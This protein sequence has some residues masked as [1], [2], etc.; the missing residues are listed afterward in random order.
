MRISDWS[1]DVCSSDLVRM[2]E[3]AQRLAA[4]TGLDAWRDRLARAMGPQARFVRALALGDTRELSD[5]DW[6]VL[7][8]T[9]LTHLIAIS[10][11][12][13]GQ[14]GRAPRRARVWQYV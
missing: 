11:F 5:R 4:A 9:G 1:S 2:P 13:V 12:H 7:R 3:A 8:A 6:E 14:I 10:G